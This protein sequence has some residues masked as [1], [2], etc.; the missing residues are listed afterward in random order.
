MIL[1]LFSFSLLLLRHI[2]LFSFTFTLTFTFTFNLYFYFYSAHLCPRCWRQNVTAQHAPPSPLTLTSSKSASRVTH[3]SICALTTLCSISRV[4]HN[5][6]M[7]AQATLCSII[8]ENSSR[9]DSDC[10]HG[11]LLRLRW[12]DV[13]VRVELQV[14]IHHLYH[15]HYQCDQPW[16]VWR[17]DEDKCKIQRQRQWRIQRPRQRQRQK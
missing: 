5:T 1:L 8:K 13:A 17:K 7:C 10:L 11:N 2:L 3:L 6:S 4:T 15:P 16:W 14:Y 12:N 9:S